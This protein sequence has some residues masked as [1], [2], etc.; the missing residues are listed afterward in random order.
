MDILGVDLAILSLPPLSSGGIGPENRSMARDRNIF[1]SDL[2]KT[3]PDRFRFFA[4][5]PMLDDT[6]G[7]S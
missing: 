3:Y 2:C 1:L 6:E 7:D 4:S 5:L